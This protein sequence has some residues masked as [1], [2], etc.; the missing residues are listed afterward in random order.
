MKGKDIP[1][2][3]GPGYYVGFSSLNLTTSLV[4]EKDS[5]GIYFKSL[6]DAF[7]YEFDRPHCEAR[8]L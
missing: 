1:E 3:L 5:C 6:I 2:P 4:L 7:T 8:T